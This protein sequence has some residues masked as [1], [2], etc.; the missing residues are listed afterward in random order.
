M[1]LEDLKTARRHAVLKAHE[2]DLPSSIQV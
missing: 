2:L 1:V